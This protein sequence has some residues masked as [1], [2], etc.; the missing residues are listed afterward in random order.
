MRTGTAKAKPDLNPF[1]TGLTSGIGTAKG[2]ASSGGYGI[3]LNLKSGTISGLSGFGN[4]LSSILASGVRQAIAAA[5]AEARIKSPSRKTFDIGRNLGRGLINGT[6]STKRKAKKSGKDLVKAMLT[7]VT[8]GTTGVRSSLDKVSEYLDKIA[9][10]RLKANEKRLRK[11]LK[12]KALDKALNN[13]EKRS[14]ASRRAIKKS[15]ADEYRA[16][17]KNAK[18]QDR[19]TRSLGQAR[20][21]L[22]QVRQQYTD[23]ATSVRT[24]AINYASVV[25]LDTAF[26]SD[27]LLDGLRSRLG[28]IEQ[29]RKIMADLIDK[30]LSKTIVDQLEQAGVEGGL[31]TALAIQQGGKDAIG[32]YNSL[33][34]QI[35]TASASLGTKGADVMYSAGI[36][37]AAG[38]VR[39]LASQDRAIDKAATRIA[40]RLRRALKNALDGK[41]QAKGSKRPTVRLSAR[42]VHAKTPSAQQRGGN[43][44]QINIKADATTDKVALGRHLVSAIDAYEAA[45]GKKRA[46]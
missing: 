43:T 22:K 45:G 35:N 11:N 4:S 6:A 3:G 23:Y 13:A 37:T 10:D 17:L 7:G 46:K 39:G 32:E 12:G 36:K 24:N 19:I 1:I 30:G 21:R 15:L 16:L 25:N 34:G 33:Q 27:A 26:N 29:Y 8:N 2:N 41:Q 28:K 14:N 9:E 44:Y 20:D 38:L 31:A 40:N 42:D 5:R 18:A